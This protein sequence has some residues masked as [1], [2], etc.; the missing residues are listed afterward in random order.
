MAS[1]RNGVVEHFPGSFSGSGTP[2]WEY[3]AEAARTTWRVAMDAALYPNNLQDDAKPYLNPLL[4]RLR[5]GFNPSLSFNEKYFSA[6]TVSLEILI[7]L[8][9]LKFLLLTYLSP[10]S[11]PRAVF[12]ERA[13]QFTSLV[14]AGF[15]MRL[16]SPQLSPR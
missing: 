12:L 4:Q 10:A 5:S 15:G 2:Q 11:L 1:V 14:G 9:C 8:L 16:S 7:L 13:T 6:D 3:G